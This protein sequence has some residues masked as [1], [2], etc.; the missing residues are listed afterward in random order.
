MKCAQLYQNWL[1]FSTLVFL[2]PVGLVNHELA[3]SAY[4]PNFLI[5]FIEAR[6]L[7]ILFSTQLL[8]RHTFAVWFSPMRSEKNSA[9]NY[10]LIYM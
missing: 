8:V 9:R 1:S 10:L 3:H 7:N 5:S 6:K 2:N 4:I